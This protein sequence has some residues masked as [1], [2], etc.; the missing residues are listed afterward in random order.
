MT[1][2]GYTALEETMKTFLCDIY[3]VDNISEEDRDGVIGTMMNVLYYY[4]KKTGFKLIKEE[5]FDSEIRQDIKNYAVNEDKFA[6]YQFLNAEGDEKKIEKYNEILATLP[7]EIAMLGNDIKDG[8]NDINHF[9]FNINPVSA[10]RL[11]ENLKNYLDRFDK[12]LQENLDEFIK[13]VEDYRRLENKNNFLACRWI[14]LYNI[15]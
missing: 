14:I 13:L 9:G 4:N 8:R 10:E 5:Q 12:F 6:R 7:I 2:Q 3:R 11:K 15:D 1:Q